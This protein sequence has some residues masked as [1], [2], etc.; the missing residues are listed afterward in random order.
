ME[1]LP[2]L[3]ICIPTYNRS[4]KLKQCLESITKQVNEYFLE[5]KI[6]L[7]ISDNCSSDNTQAVIK[8]I[9]IENPNFL[10][11]TY[12]Q[13]S[14]LGFAR[15]VYQAWSLATGKYLLTS[16]DDD[17]FRDGSLPFILDQLD[18]DQSRMIIFSNARGDGRFFKQDNIAK[19]H[20]IR[21]GLQANRDLGVF[22]LSFIG[23][24]IIES[25]LFWKHFATCYLS[26]AYPHTCVWLSAL[27]HMSE[28]AKFIDTPTLL[29]DDS[30]RS[31]QESQPLL[32]A[33]DMATIQTTVN[34]IHSPN[35][36]E[37]YAT[38]Q[39]L[40]RSL[41]RAIYRNRFGI[42]TTMSSCYSS[43][44]YQNILNAYGLST[45][46]KTLAVSIVFIVRACP[47]NVLKVLKLN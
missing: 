12:R 15:N 2:F 42:I 35:K 31:W 9:Q 29:I 44:S 7:C 33:I 11:R 16:G 6:E 40:I 19:T 18:G 41:P 1:S 46:Y 24:V 32:T 8:T 20:L 10:V 28:V 36:F 17:I 39:K 38:Y 45:L 21:D 26:S 4:E 27:N 22:H 43:L 34:L 5:S 23:N 37:I 47:L 3:S 30:C 13:Q 25:D 14:N